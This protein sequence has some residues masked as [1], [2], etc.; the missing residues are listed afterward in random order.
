[1]F[2]I[3]SEFGF[4]TVGNTVDPGRVAAQVVAGVGFL[5]AG[6]I[7]KDVDGYVRGLTTAAGLWVSAAI[8]LMVGAGLYLA[9]F[10]SAILAFIILDA[11]TLFPFFFKHDVPKKKEPFDEDQQ[12]IE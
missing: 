3:V 8:G 9:G 12:S 1:M 5:G 4:P 10:I 6:T 11:P 7:I 2:A